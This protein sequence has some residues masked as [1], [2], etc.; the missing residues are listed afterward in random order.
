MVWKLEAILTHIV[1]CYRK[2]MSQQADTIDVTRI[3]FPTD[4]LTIK[5]VR[6]AENPED[7]FDERREGFLSNLEAIVA[8]ER[9][10]ARKAF[11]ATLKGSKPNRSG[12]HDL[13]AALERREMISGVDY[14]YQRYGLSSGGKRW[15]IPAILELDIPRE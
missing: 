9:D 7:G 4:K 14:D 3:S 8:T 11:Q 12:K 10:L 2:D 6:E 15:P 13:D 5:A 1:C